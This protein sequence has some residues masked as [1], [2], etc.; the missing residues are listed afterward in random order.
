VERVE[1]RGSRRRCL[2]VDLLG[3]AL[4]LWLASAGAAAALSFQVDFVAS[5]YDTQPGDTFSDLLLRHQAG[6]PIQSTVTTGLENISN[7]VYAAGVTSDYS[8]MMT[9]TLEVVTPGA[10][11]FQVGTDWGRGGATALIDDGTGSIVSERVIDDD[12]WWAY[13]WNNPDVFT[14][15]FNFDPGDSY[16]LVWVGFEGCCG[17][18]T[19]VRFSVDGSPYAPLTTTDFGPFVVVPE[20]GPVLLLGLGLA[21][22]GRQQGRDGGREG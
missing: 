13:N 19:T 8:M 14:T 9:T 20:P 2:A 3:A 4:A 21:W 16:T 7:T 11:T 6:T 22:L 15:T 1:S 17:G 5:T 18:S 10:Y 12:V